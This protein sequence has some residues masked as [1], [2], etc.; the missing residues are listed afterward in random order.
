LARLRLGF[1]VYGGINRRDWRTVSVD[2]VKAD[3]NEVR[4]DLVPM[5]RADLAPGREAV[6]GWTARLV[7]ECRERLSVLLPLNEA[8]R[9]FLDR[10]ND[11]GEIVPGLIT[12][13]PA[14]QATIRE[15]P[16]LRWKALNVRRHRGLDAA[17]MI[18][19]EP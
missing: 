4:M 9:A 16:G 17:E 6:A 11:A 13:D 12:K 1:V 10:L 2:D 3:V 19:G 18:D 7:A 15:H 8:E 5:L 14:L